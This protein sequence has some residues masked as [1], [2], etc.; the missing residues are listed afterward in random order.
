MEDLRKNHSSPLPGRLPDLP[1][2]SDT[3]EDLFHRAILSRP[4]DL[5]LLL[6][7]SLPKADLEAAFVDNE[8]TGA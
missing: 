2:L 4:E 6:S 1:D 7:P 5:R 3:A 8:N